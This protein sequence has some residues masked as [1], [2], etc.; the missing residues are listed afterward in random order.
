MALSNVRLADVIASPAGQLSH[1]TQRLL[2][3]ARAVALKPTVLLFD[4]PA[5]G[6]SVVEAEVLKDVIRSLA[7]SGLPVLLVEHNLPVVFGVA[8]K[9]TVLH[10]GEVLASGTPA[11]V[12]ADPE[13]SRVYL[14]RRNQGYDRPR[15]NVEADGA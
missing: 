2:E 8:D 14:G 10:Q 3:I 6:L 11:E 12:G 4:E 7:A 15:S 5:A 1:G 13:V 9:V